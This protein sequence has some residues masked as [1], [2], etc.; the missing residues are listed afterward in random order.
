MTIPKTDTTID[1]T[2]AKV[3]ALKR[4]Y[5]AAVRAG[6]ETFTFDDNGTPHLFVTKYA[7]YLLAY[8]HA[9]HEAKRHAQKE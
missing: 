5:A 4:A 6:Q 2:P 1:F 8:L 3:E 7:M 9:Q